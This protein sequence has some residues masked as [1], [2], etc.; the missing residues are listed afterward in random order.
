MP[1]S[2]GRSI[3]TRSAAGQALRV[4]LV[5]GVLAGTEYACQ[6]TTG[7]QLGQ[8]AIPVLLPGSVNGR[9]LPGSRLLSRLPPHETEH[10]SHRCKGLSSTA[11]VNKA[12]DLVQGQSF[13][14]GMLTTGQTASDP[15]VAV[16]ATTLVKVTNPEGI[17]VYDK[18]SGIPIP[19]S[20]VLTLDNFF[21]GI[22]VFDCCRAHWLMGRRTA[23]LMPITRPP[24]PASSSAMAIT[25]PAGDTTAPP[26]A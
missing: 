24:L 7:G 6:R 20:P 2:F 17:Q 19:S 10:L 21:G 11:F 4:A 1:R 16:G 9:I 23:S 15:V 5:L 26:M 14:G 18:T 3:S 8:K 13:D 12:S 22:G 25:V